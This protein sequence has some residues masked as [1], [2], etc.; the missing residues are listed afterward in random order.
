MN[1]LRPNMCKSK[2]IFELVLC[3][4]LLIFHSS[5]VKGQKEESELDSILLEQISALVYLDSITITPEGSD[6]EKDRF[7]QYVLEDESF[8][9][10]FLNLRFIGHSFNPDIEFFNKKNKKVDYYTGI[11]TQW[12][13]GQCRNMRI[14]EQYHSKSYFK[15]NKKYRYYTSKLIDR[16]FYTQGQ[17]CA[18]ST[19]KVQPA[20]D[21]KFEKYVEDL[22]TVIF[23]PGKNVSVPLVGNKLSIFSEEM[24]QYY[25]Y[26]I[27]YLP[28]EN[29]SFCYLFDVELKPE[30]QEISNKT[31]ISKMTT[32]FQEDNFQILKRS[33]KLRNQNI[34]YTFEIDINVSLTKWN[35]KYVPNHVDYDG[36]WKIVGKK[37]EVCKFQFNFYEF[38]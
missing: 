13:K 27:S 22:K 14:D 8:Y 24:Q 35:S 11:H 1:T 20:P 25:V 15:K 37:P 30:F 18:D 33:Y 28:N 23:S 32:W 5:N 38:N 2:L 9:N 16:V 29:G 6:L 19:I 17:I 12:M 34:L 7:I 36:F 4:A 3:L 31:V 21:S 26:S 10:A